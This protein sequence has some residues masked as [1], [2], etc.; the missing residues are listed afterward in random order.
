[1]AQ[2]SDN[3]YPLFPRKKGYR[4]GDYIMVCPHRIEERLRKTRIVD[5]Q[6]GKLAISEILLYGH[7]FKG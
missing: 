4:K 5:F 2:L 6:R 7:I 3:S 1:M